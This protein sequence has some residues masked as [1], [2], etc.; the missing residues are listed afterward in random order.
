M[1]RS[2]RR[3]A[4]VQST[5]RELGLT[6]ASAPIVPGEPSGSSIHQQRTVPPLKRSRRQQPPEQRMHFRHNP[7]V[8]RQHPTQLLQSVAVTY[9]RGKSHQLIRA[10]ASTEE[11]M[12]NPLLTAA[13]AA[14]SACGGAG[15][16]R[17]GT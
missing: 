6:V 13:S 2:R 9:R 1:T 12:G 3:T 7:H 8:A 14:A 17:P 11:T 15:D 10:E 4:W 16:V 5:A